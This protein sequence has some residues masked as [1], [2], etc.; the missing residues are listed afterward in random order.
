M[1]F[2]ILI[3]DGTILDGS[4]QPR[5]RGDVGISSGAI[6]AV[7]NPAL[8]GAE[9]PKVI[10]AAGKFVSPGFVDITSHADTSGALLLNPHQGYLLTQGV[11]SILGG[12]CGASLAPIASPEAVGA[13]SKWGFGSAANV[14]WLTFGKFLDELSK[15]PLGVNFGTLVG[16]DTLRRGILRGESRVMTPEELEQ[17]RELLSRSLDE[18]AFGLSTGLVY[19]HEAPATAAEL[20][21]MS[22]VLAAKGTIYKTHLRSEGANLLA[23]VNEAIQISRESG[24]SIIISHLKAIGR[25]S[26]PF[27]GRAL[28][29]IGRTAEDGVK[30]HF[31]LSPYRRTGSF[32]YLLLPAW[33][34]EG[35]FNVM[36]ER[37]RKPEHRSA[38]IGELKSA[39]LHFDRYIVA[40]PQGGGRTIAEL[41]ELST[42][43]P[44]EVMLNLLAAS[45]GRAIV[46][47]R[48]V[49]FPNIVTGIRH[50][51][52]V[53]ASDGTG[54]MAEADRAGVL[55]HPRSTGCFPHFL[56]MFVR[57]KE[58]VSWEEGIHKITSRPAELVGFKGRGRIAP[59]FAADIVVFDPEQIRDRSTYQNPY[60]H[61]IGIEAVIVN[62]KLAVEN[63]QLT[64][65]AAGEV[66]KKA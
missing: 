55:V 53:V 8:E 62:G 31:D 48:T 65:T 20:T 34:R 10:D 32:L 22:R 43:P 45:R 64:G 58:I 3:K 50:P 36:L 51:L 35:G 46:L 54:V 14:N 15:Q 21:A 41:A 33:A 49:S 6:A 27:F 4:G 16:H 23:A 42:S 26:W 18:G 52:A 17:F 12:N 59:K 39:T 30:V 63:G 37:L 66:L 24:A 40:S 60:V 56:H 19:G 25:K 44:E 7:G 9:A 2:D 13:L 11:T 5:F 47:G 1:T 28:E 29:M 38:I 57:E 61:P